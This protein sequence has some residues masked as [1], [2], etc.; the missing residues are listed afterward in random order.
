[1][2]A[3]CMAC[4]AEMNLKNLPDVHSGWH[5]EGVQHDVHRR[6]IGEIRHILF[7]QNLCYHTFVAIAARHLI[8]DGDMARRC[9]KDFHQFKHA[10]FQF[11]TE[12]HPF[13]RT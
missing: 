5:A 9:D 13:Q 3:Q 11:V 8:A 12:F 7:G 6:S 4:P 1:M 2:D 10:G